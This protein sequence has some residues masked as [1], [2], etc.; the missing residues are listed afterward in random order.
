MIHVTDLFITIFVCCLCLDSIYINTHT[1]THTHIYIYIHTHTH[2]QNVS[3][4]RYPIAGSC[5]RVLL[6]LSALPGKGA[7]SS[8]AIATN[9]CIKRFS[10]PTIP[11]TPRWAVWR[12]PPGNTTRRRGRRRKTAGGGQIRGKR[13]QYQ[14]GGFEVEDK[15]GPE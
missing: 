5:G 8:D 13:Q 15:G 3:S 9:G 7:A 1:H 6:H 2:T 10:V 11:P 4:N 12:S 14:P